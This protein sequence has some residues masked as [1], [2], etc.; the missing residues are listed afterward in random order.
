MAIGQY[1]LVTTPLQ[2]AM[3]VQ[4]IAND[5]LMMEPILVD[6]VKGPGRQQQDGQIGPGPWDM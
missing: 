6:A 4:A 5:G 1:G 3:V 2:M